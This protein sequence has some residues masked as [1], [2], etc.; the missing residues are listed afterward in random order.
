MQVIV[1]DRFNNFAEVAGAITTQDAIRGLTN[2][3]AYKG[4]IL[5]QG[6]HDKD[7]HVISVL[8]RAL[9]LPCISL[10]DDPAKAGRE[11]CHKHFQHNELIS[12]PRKVEDNVFEADVLV[13]D[14]NEIMSDHVTGCHLQGMLLIE[15]IRQMFIAVSE[16]QYEH[17]GVPVGGY[18]V[19]NKLDV[20]FEQF[21]FPIATS[22]RQTV[23]DFTQPRDDRARFVA[24]VE[25]F[26]EQGRVATAEVDYTVF[27]N[28]SLQPKEEKL[29]Q[30]AVQ[31]LLTKYAPD[32]V[33][34][35][36]LAQPL[37][38]VG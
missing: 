24:T 11:I 33:T 18:V 17:L 9:G 6:V 25:V 2:G 28:T 35:N 23:N 31:R 7:A 8:S 16:T 3:A 30:K 22:L 36:E 21:A 19:F 1:G 12:F 38:A 10:A 4:F 27:E 26:Q 15:G 34:L 37:K 13:D 20:K 32:P 14:R 5:G 29:A